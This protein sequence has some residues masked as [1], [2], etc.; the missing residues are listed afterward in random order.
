M[1]TP[2]H[3]QGVQSCSVCV[4]GCV[5]ARKKVE[6]EER[7]A[8]SPLS[9]RCCCQWT[10]GIHHLQNTFHMRKSE[11][12]NQKQNAKA[13][14]ALQQGGNERKKDT[15]QWKSNTSSRRNS[16]KA[17]EAQSDTDEETSHIQLR[18]PKHQGR[19]GLDHVGSI[20]ASFLR[21]PAITF[22]HVD[23]QHRHP[24]KMEHAEKQM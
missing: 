22:P 16:E 8:G 5:H 14:Q 12:E 18:K 23:S 13:I 1:H 9:C 17:G 21:V 4:C 19:S 2:T 7:A 6:E 3:G 15:A 20:K 24:I 11:G 10:A